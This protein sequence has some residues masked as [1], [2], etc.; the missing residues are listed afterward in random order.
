M[1][2]PALGD[3][4][5][6]CDATGIVTTRPQGAQTGRNSLCDYIDLERRLECSAGYIVNTPPPPTEDE[7]D[8]AARAAIPKL[9]AFAILALEEPHDFTTAPN[10][11]HRNK[12]AELRSGNHTDV[13]GLTDSIEVQITHEFAPRWCALGDGA[14]ARHDALE[15]IVHLYAGAAGRIEIH[16]CPPHYA[17]LVDTYRRRALAANGPE[18]HFAGRRIIAVNPRALDVVEVLKSGGAPLL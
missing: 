17:N 8:E 11:K 18:L 2:L 5:P 3:P 6:R 4:C 16:L 12:L 9:D 7:V 13:L 14:R 1:T 10:I 15:L